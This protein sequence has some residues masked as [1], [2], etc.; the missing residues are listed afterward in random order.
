MPCQLPKSDAVDQGEIDIFLGHIT[1]SRRRMFRRL[2]FGWIWGYGPICVDTNDP[3]TQYYGM[4]KRLARDL[5]S[6]NPFLLARIRGFI[7]KWLA[8]NVDPIGPQDVLLLFEQWLEHT[9]Y[10]EQRKT[11]LRATW[12]SMYCTNPTPEQLHRVKAFIKTEFYSDFKFARWICSRVDETK[13]WW[14]PWCKLVEHA[15]F[16]LPYFVKNLTVDQRKARVRSMPIRDYIIGT[17]FTAFESHFTLEVLQSFEFL[18]YDHVL[19]GW[20]ELNVLKEMLGGCNRVSTRLGTKAVIDARRMSGDMNTSLGNGFTN[21]MLIEFFLQDVA[22]DVLVEGDD[23]LIVSDGD[24]S[25]LEYEKAGFSIKIDHFTCVGEA[26]FCGLV[27]GDSGQVIKDPYKFLMGAGWTE[28]LLNAGDDKLWELVVAKAMSCLAETPHCPI[29]AAWALSALSHA[30]A[31]VKPRWFEDGYHGKPTSIDYSF[32][33]TDDTR[34]LFEKKYNISVSLQ[35]QCERLIE[36]G[37][38]IELARVLPAPSPS[39]AYF[40]MFMERD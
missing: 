31:G 15:L 27:F 35:L 4:V 17:D 2:P 25:E 30:P 37:D 21:L 19:S 11:A 20:M 38:F 12:E 34:L 7:R 28:H 24:L 36:M 40:S 8:D 22:H 16:R 29:V 23:G 18:L 3:E 13:V 14:G 33:P 6:P 5:P 26:S 10:N 39:F 1:R 32:A 9:S